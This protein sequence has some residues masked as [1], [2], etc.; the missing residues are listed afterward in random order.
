M[1][2]P[3]PPELL[4]RAARYEDLTRW[5]RAELGRS[6]RRLGWTYGEI[7]ES[8]P[9]AKSTVSYWC[10]DIRLTDEQVDAIKKRVAGSRRGVPVDTQ[11][12]RRIEIEGIE[13]RARTRART[14]IH[15]PFWV[16]GVV[17]YWG[18]GMK[19]H[20]ILAVANSDAR[21]LNV[22]IAWTRRYFDTDAAFTLALNLHARNDEAAA[23][24]YW[25][26]VLDIEAPAFTK[27]FRKPAGTG[28]R[29]NHL[30]NGVC[31]VRVRK[32]T[33]AW[34]ETMAWIDA[35]AEPLLTSAL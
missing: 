10:R 7:R 6:L 4:A 9:V 22:F 33:N 27:T 24:R 35:I 8:L 34:I 1:R 15:D 13:T 32:S 19:T 11:W 20:R 23:R 31:R 28:H 5:E 2:P 16:A 17:L 18:E 30:P 26:T 14:L 29:K 21:L 12:R 3:A 25:S